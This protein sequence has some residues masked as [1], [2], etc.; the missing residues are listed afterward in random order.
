MNFAILMNNLG[1]I[2]SGKKGKKTVV[3]LTKSN[4]SPTTT[5]TCWLDLKK[6]SLAKVFCSILSINDSEIW[7]DSG[8]RSILSMISPKTTMMLEKTPKMTNRKKDY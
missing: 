6:V 4:P 7:R 2:L 3:L 8:I 5:S 1:Y